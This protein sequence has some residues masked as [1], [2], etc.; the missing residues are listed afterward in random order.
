VFGPFR[1]CIVEPHPEKNQPFSQAQDDNMLRR[2]SFSSIFS[3]SGFSALQGAAGA[4]AHSRGLLNFWSASS[5]SSSAPPF[6][7][8]TVPTAAVAWTG[9]RS[10]SRKVTKSSAIQAS[11]SRSKLRSS[12]ATPSRLQFYKGGHGL[13]PDKHVCISNASTIEKLEKMLVSDQFMFIRAP[14]SSGKSVLALHLHRHLAQKRPTAFIDTLPTGD[15]TTADDIKKNIMLHMTRAVTEFN[16]RQPRP[17]P[18]SPS[19]APLRLDS[20]ARDVDTGTFDTL[21]GDFYRRDGVLILDEA[22]L[23]WPYAREVSSVFKGAS[24]R[25][26]AFSAA[27]EANVEGKQRETVTPPDLFERY[28]W[29]PPQPDFSSLR[30]Q[31]GH[32]GVPIDGH[33]LKFVWRLCGGHRGLVMRL[34]EWLGKQQLRS[35]LG[36]SQVQWSLSTTAAAVMG[37]LGRRCCAVIAAAAVSAR[38]VI[39]AAAASAGNDRVEGVAEQPRRQ[40][41]RELHE[42]AE[43]PA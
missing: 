14:P 31:C 6:F 33:A 32:A 30:E 4:A 39:S 25:V 21:V 26:V 28:F 12:A 18:S 27:S 20:P 15:S 8:F 23:L 2:G 36:A 16:E 40:G 13:V 22:H 19:S 43:H 5:P 3:S 37:G 24:P 10:A 41:Q 34:L 38:G 29:H 42:G 1:F 7:S 17:S 35:A 9:H 11:S